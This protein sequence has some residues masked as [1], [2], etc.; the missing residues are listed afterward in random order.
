MDRLSPPSRRAL[1]VAC[2]VLLLISL[3]SWPAGAWAFC[4]M[5]VTPFRDVPDCD[6]YALA[7]YWPGRSLP[8]RSHWPPCWPPAISGL[9]LWCGASW[10]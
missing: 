4:Y 2:P 6:W 8:W 3:T 7:W 10:R 5:G 9:T 1:A